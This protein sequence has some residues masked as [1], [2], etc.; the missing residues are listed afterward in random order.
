MKELFCQTWVTEIG[1][2]VADSPEL[3]R[4]EMTDPEK[5]T[6]GNRFLY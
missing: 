6:Q 4:H 2:K 5:R 1:V 3:E